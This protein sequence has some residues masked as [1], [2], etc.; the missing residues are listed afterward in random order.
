MPRDALDCSVVI[1][2]VSQE[3]HCGY[4]QLVEGLAHITPEQCDWRKDH[5]NPLT[6]ESE[7]DVFVLF[8]ALESPWNEQYRGV[9]GYPGWFK[10][11]V[12]IALFVYLLLSEHSALY[13]GLVRHREVHHCT[14]LPDE[15]LLFLECTNEPTTLCQIKQ[16]EH[17]NKQ[18]R[19]VDS[20]R[21]QM[22][23]TNH[24]KRLINLD[25]LQGIRATGFSSGPPVI[26]TDL[27]YSAVHRPTSLERQPKDDENYRD[28]RSLRI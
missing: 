17:Q 16:N 19:E 12:G 21:Y 9:V 27:R 18:Y 20:E 14:L 15:L 13:C 3:I 22:L 5:P 1:A 11:C 28:S 26:K 10:A 23:S 4:N 24:L 8:S 25:R 2:D 6:S 7:A